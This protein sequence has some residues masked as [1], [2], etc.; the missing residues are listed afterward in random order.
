MTVEAARREKAARA[1]LRF[2]WAESRVLDDASTGEM[3]FPSSGIA[4][5]EIRYVYRCIMRDEEGKKKE[6]R[7]GNRCRDHYQPSAARLSL[8][9]PSHSASRRPPDQTMQ[10]EQHVPA[11]ARPAIACPTRGSC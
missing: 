8:H 11:R 2:S 4:E 1:P 6:T 7:E 10:L 3:A 5:S 9:I